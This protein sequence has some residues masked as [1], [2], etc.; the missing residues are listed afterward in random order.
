MRLLQRRFHAPA[1]VVTTDD[2]VLHLED[3]DRILNHAEAI[4]VR[5]DDL[6]CDISVREYLSGFGVHDD[7]A[8]HTAVRATYPKKLGRL[9]AG[10]SLKI[11]RVP[12]LDVEGPSLVFKDQLF[13][14]M[15]FMAAQ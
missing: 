4:D 13:V 11:V 9:A 8:G 14:R 7:V 1:I 10:E 2:D 3:I 5:R 15:H 6:V 12:L